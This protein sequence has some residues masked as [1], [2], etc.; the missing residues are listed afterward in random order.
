M[1]K[2]L[3]G[4]CI[5]SDRKQFILG[6]TKKDKAGHTR[7]KDPRYF[8]TLQGAVKESIRRLLCEK[9]A[10]NEITTLLQFTQEAERLNAEFQ[11]IIRPL[12]TVRDGLP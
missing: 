6:Q 12:A 7:F 9:V 1:I 8:P 5:K 3:G 10:D 11:E 4:Y 2:L